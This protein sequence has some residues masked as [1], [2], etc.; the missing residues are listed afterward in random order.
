MA[1]LFLCFKSLRFLSW[2]TSEAYSSCYKIQWHPGLATTNTEWISD[3]TH[4]TWNFPRGKAITVQTCNVLPWRSKCTLSAFLFYSEGHNSETMLRK[5]YVLIIYFFYCGA[6]SPS[7][8]LAM[9]FLLTVYS[10]YTECTK[11]KLRS[12]GALLQNGTQGQMQ[13][14]QG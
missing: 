3:D 9:H 13:M 4:E 11:N 14:M 7:I 6:D 10:V 1:C 5:A 2:G 8:G 12:T